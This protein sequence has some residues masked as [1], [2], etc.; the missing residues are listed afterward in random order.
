MKWSVSHNS[1]LQ[2]GAE[3][4]IP[5]LI[6]FLVALGGAFRALRAVQRSPLPRPPGERSPPEAQLAQAL[7]AALIGYMVGGFFLSLAYHD[8]LYTL[9]ALIVALRK[10]VPVAATPGLRGIKPPSLRRFS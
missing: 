2:V 8:L 1:F 10:V 5:G 7:S 9:L 4:G 6:A 3:L